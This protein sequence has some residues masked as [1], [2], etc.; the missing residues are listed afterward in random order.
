MG[1]VADGTSDP[2]SIDEIGLTLLK[3][4]AQIFTQ[5]RFQGYSSA[6]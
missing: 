6:L 4:V 1:P 3:H 5:D 2:G